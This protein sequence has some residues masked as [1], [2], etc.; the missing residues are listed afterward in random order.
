MT[1]LALSGRCGVGVHLVA[2]ADAQPEVHDAMVVPVECLV[3]V[4]DA[5]GALRF[6]A[7]LIQKGANG[8]FARLSILVALLPHAHPDY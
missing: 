6:R 4:V 1:W 5:D 3:W 2:V 7:E 8:R